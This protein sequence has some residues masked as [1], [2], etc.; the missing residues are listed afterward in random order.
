MIGF[1]FSGAFA[2]GHYQALPIILALPCSRDWSPTITS[3]YAGTFRMAAASYS[4]ARNQSRVPGG[5]GA[6]LLVANFSVT[7]AMSGWAAMAYFRVP[8]AQVA[9]ATIAT[10]LLVGG[11]NY[12]GP[13]HS[14]SVACGWLFRWCWQSCD[15]GPQHCFGP[16]FLCQPAAAGTAHD[17]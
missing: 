2:V 1:A 14:G 17:A 9:I 10:I 3:S 11:I 7:A 13:K 6:L 5:D 12:F 16:A 4:A 8:D 15:F